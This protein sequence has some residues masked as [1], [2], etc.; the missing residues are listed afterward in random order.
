MKYQGANKV[1]KNN[2]TSD[3]VTNYNYPQL[4]NAPNKSLFLN[5]LLLNLLC[6]G[7]AFSIPA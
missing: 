6:T 4:S 7:M 3:R 5:S 2:T 1:S